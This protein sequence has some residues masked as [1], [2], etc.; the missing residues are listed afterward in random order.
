MKVLHTSDWHLGI[1]LDNQYRDEEHKAALKWLSNLIKSEAVEVLII[2]GDVF[3]VYT[4][5]NSAQNLYYNFLKS[6]VNTA[7]QHI[8]IVAGNHDSPNLLAAAKE[9]LAL[10][11]IY[12]VANISKDL[13]AQILPLYDNNTQELK[14]VIAA[15]PYL[16]EAVLRSTHKGENSEVRHEQIKEAIIQHYEDLAQLISKYDD[17]KVPFIATGHLFV[18]GADSGNKNHLTYL[19]FSD[20]IPSTAFPKKFDYIALGHLH[21]AHPVNKE[22][23]IRYSGSLIP[24]DFSES[25][26]QHQV[27]II[28]FE[29]KNIKEILSHKVDVPRNLIYKQGKLEEIIQFLQAYPSINNTDF[30]PKM[31]TWLKVELQSDKGFMTNVK[32]QLE[33]YT[34]DK[35]I[36][37]LGEPLQRMIYKDNN[38]EEGNMAEIRSLESLSVEEVFEMCMT[39]QNIEQESQNNLKEDFRALQV[40]WDEQERNK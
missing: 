35:N 33:P 24:L 7:C 27:Y 6:L 20:L 12:V 14:T 29:G 30:K 15:V 18:S 13:N 34:I 1:K 2:A 17:A 4:P 21:K 16:S 9:L 26:Y 3:D 36:E 11:N 37:I 38:F 31:K 19:G 25:E 22:G 5:S 39:A 28:E 8:V 23:N 10:L 40:W 32:D